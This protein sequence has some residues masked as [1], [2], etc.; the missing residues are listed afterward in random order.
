MSTSASRLAFAG[1]VSVLVF[2]SAAKAENPSFEYREGVM[3]SV[4]GHTKAAALIIK[5]QVP[6]SADLPTHANALD[7]LAKMSGHIFNEN[8]RDPKSKAKAAIWEKPEEFKKS[9][10]AFQ[11]AAT[12]FAAVASAGDPRASAP[13]FSELTK[14][15]KSCH[16]D[17][18]T[19]D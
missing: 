15:C 6:F 13:A 3:D 7:T 8:S 1:L 5:G 9:L 14:T 19:K 11:A 18:R 4:G 12:N 10:T 17:F 16:D 2:G